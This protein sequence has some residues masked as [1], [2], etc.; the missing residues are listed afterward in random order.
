MI[1]YLAM[2]TGFGSIFV[3]THFDG[4]APQLIH[5]FRQVYWAREC[6]KQRH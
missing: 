1:S 2:A 4:H 3:S 5:L 6:M